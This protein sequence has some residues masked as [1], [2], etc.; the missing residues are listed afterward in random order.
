MLCD[1]PKDV[2]SLKSL[3]VGH[4][5]GFLG[6]KLGPEMIKTVLFGYVSFPF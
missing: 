4:I 6:G 3:V 1:S 2:V 5:L